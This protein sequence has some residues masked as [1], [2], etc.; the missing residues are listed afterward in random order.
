VAY[1]IDGAAY[2][3]SRLVLVHRLSIDPGLGLRPPT[4]AEL[5]TAIAL[6]SVLV[7]FATRQFRARPIAAFGI[8]WFLLHALFPYVLLPRVDVVNER[9][10]YVANAGLFVAAGA[11]WADFIAWPG[12]LPGARRFAAVVAGLLL[13]GTALRNLDYRSETALWESTVRVSPG[14]P[15]AHNNL[16]IAYESTGRTV[17]ARTAYARAVFL[18]PTY[19]SARRN[20]ER[21]ENHA[22]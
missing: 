3:L 4:A 19:L 7:V 2:L 21:V 5:S 18:E 9:H 12:V 11:L 10:M 17:E 20:L 6:S 14:N 13:M 15:R 22:P 16:G 1:Q 8:L